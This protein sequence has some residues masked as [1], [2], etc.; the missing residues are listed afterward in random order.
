MTRLAVSMIVLTALAVASC[1]SSAATP[2]SV[3]SATPTLVPSEPPPSV[4]TGTGAPV[5]DPS[6]FVPGVD[7]PW[8][9]LVPGTRLTYKGT[10]DG[11]P[12]IDV[13]EIT[14]E[15]KVIDGV[16]C[17]VIRDTLTL[18][19]KLHEK[20]EDW[21]AQDRQGNVWYF[22][23]DTA[24]YDE[25]GRVTGTAGS[26]QA[27]VDGAR[28]GI[29]MPGDPQIGQSFQQEFYAGQAE[30]HFVVLLLSASVKVPYGSFKDALLTAEWTPLEPDVLSEKTYV[31]GIGQ[32]NE[33]DITGGKEESQLLDVQ[34]P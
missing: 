22:G 25:Q 6:D 30:D 28:P 10:K 26:W 2:H 18:S 21:Y 20:T 4:V 1:G 12:A 15:T 19:G 27:G 34:R 31:K 24:E 13:F 32:V 16:T 33:R 3:P 7:N 23:E 9:P 5:V 29:F 14:G 11:E 8:F 17:E